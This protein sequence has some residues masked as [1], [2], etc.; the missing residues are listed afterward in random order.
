MTALTHIRTGL[1]TISLL[2]VMLLWSPFVA[3]A[4]KNIPQTADK[5]DLNRDGIVNYDDLVIFSSKFLN[6]YTDMMDWCIFYDDVYTGNAVYGKPADFFINHYSALLAFINN[7]FNCDG[8]LSDLNQDARVNARD[9]MEFGELY[10]GEHFLQVDWCAFLEGIL[11]GEDQYGYPADF[12]L[13]KFG[14]LLLY[15][16]DKYTCSDSPPANA[17]VLKNLPKFL[18]RMAASRNL[19]GD[20]YVTDAK[21]GSIF[22][23]N[24]DLVLTQELK[25]LAKPLGIAVNALG[26][27]LVGNDKRN[28][29]EVYNPDNGEKLTTFGETELETPS[30][31][32]L[33]SQGKV[34]VS[35]AGSNTIYI[36]D[37]AYN[38]IASIGEPGRDPDQLR[39]PSNALLSADE[40][41]IFVLDRLNKRVQ[42][43]DPESI[44]PDNN[45]LRGFIFEGTPGENCNWFTKICEIPGA[46]A[47]TRI[48]AMDFDISG[49]LHVLDVFHAAVTIF[50]PQTGEFIGTYGT[51]GLGD[52]ELK[53][54]V[55]LIVETDRVLVLDGGKNKIEVLAIP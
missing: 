15:I 53:S 41:E 7:Y 42:V 48:Q 33:D 11:N 21:V 35:D 12:Y 22:I 1:I 27:I 14:L 29:V 17:L 16:Q 13:V 23:Y 37:T 6:S 54:P 52:G 18:T 20:Y 2:F 38:L 25:G 45:W 46:P 8:D 39:A 31:I 47:F 26:H 50:D 55:D 5:S 30:S 4:D 36:Y 44:D 9:L 32:M 28:N 43:Y 24:S 3:S 49:R 10:A 34:Y 51:Y 19:T 40:S